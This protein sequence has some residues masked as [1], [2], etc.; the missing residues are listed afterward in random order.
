MRNELK[1]ELAEN[2][3]EYAAAVNSDRAIPDAKCGLKPVA[4]RILYGAYADGYSSNKKHTKC[5][6]IV[7]EIMKKYH[8]HGD[9]SIYGALV[10]LSQP[11]VMRYPLIDFHGANGS[12]NG[13]G[14]A[15]YRYTEARLSKLAEDGL[16][17]GLKKNNVDFIPTYSDDWVEP[18]TLP[19]IFPNLLCNPNSGI[20]VAIAS[21]WLPHNLN[22]VAQAI[23][24]YIDGKEP[25]LPGPD[26]PTGGLVINKDD[27]PNIF[28][29]GHGSVKI[30]SKYK[31]EGNNIVFYEI[32]YG[33][34]IED[35]ITE[36]G[37]VC[38]T[39]GFEDVKDLRDETNKHGVRIV[40]ECT[41][42][43]N[44]K[45]I[46]NKLFAKTK[47]QTSI[48]Y[49]QVALVNKTPVELNLK[50]CIKIYIE[51]NIDCITKETQFDL[52]KA[53]DRLH[54]LNGLLIALEDIDNIIKLIKSSESA[55]MAKENLMN[56]YSLSENQAKS[57]LDMKLSK[58]AK[59]EKIEIET[60]KKELIE[61]VN[62]LSNILADKNLQINIIKDKLSDIVKK[63]GDERRTE[64][65]QIKEEPEEKEIINV[66]PEKC[67]VV[68][69][70]GG[71]IK[72]IPAA[73]FKTQ[74]RNG[75]GI[76]TQEDIT[77][78][79][80]RTNTVDSLM[81]FTDKGKMYRLLVDDIP[82][83][84][85]ASKGT[86]IRNL[87]TLEPDE[88]PT[89]IYSIY[90]DTDAKYV[91]FVT[92]KGKVKKTALDEYIKM[93]KKSGIGALRIAE[94]DELITV[95]LIKDEPLTL[96]TNKGYSITFDSKEIGASSR[97]TQ[98]IKGL[99]LGKDDFVVAALPIRHAE[100]C[101]AVFSRA[102]LGK[103]IS[104]KELTIQKKGGRGILCYKPTA[105]SGP[106]VAACL[107]SDE[108]NVLVVGNKSSICISAKE[109]PL[110]S[111]TC[112]GNMI[113]KGNIVK[114]A[115]KV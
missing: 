62:L 23:F 105:E 74:K 46:V 71:T 2:F 97:L 112:L 103:K 92:K 72:R 57:I 14:P 22:E 9:S 47:L 89:V 81:I 53:K 25:I 83:G 60:E 35:L 108:D 30:R 55:K 84:T 6:G 38:E 10:R 85:N 33:Q 17:F 82:S 26:F 96:I 75:K 65:I 56:K 64:L 66:V 1:Q 51:H 28:K 4:R 32:P 36:I 114:S 86:P 42:N 8:P 88:N 24:D 73:S 40:L 67:V 76:K 101:L 48:S 29:T 49:N 115:T 70:E 107:V 34:T 39:E 37:A 18:V 90:R 91:L 11:W 31:I 61:K 63:Y 16:L 5:A 95:C 104:P 110:L 13:D 93:K 41:K 21:N 102:G 100:D 87:I 19:S 99:T 111:R 79:I 59:L 80:L 43:A 27:M 50:D 78:M 109:I 3:I 45:S 20:G 7:G 69:T 98:G 52:T 54:I 77:S 94:D 68:L 106:V 58:L 15:A 44:F 12:Q 113:L